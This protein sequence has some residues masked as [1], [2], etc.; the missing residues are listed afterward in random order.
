MPRTERLAT[1]MFIVQIMSEPLQALTCAQVT[2]LSPGTCKH[3]ASR[4]WQPGD[5]SQL[6]TVN[7]Q[8]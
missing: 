6:T 5:E 3:A 2:A 4:G 7:C 1:L 8:A